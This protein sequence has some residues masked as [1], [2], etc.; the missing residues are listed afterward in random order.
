M[1]YAALL[2]EDD[3]IG[4]KTRDEFNLVDG[5]GNPKRNLFGDTRLIQNALWLKS[6]I[7]SSDGAVTRMASYLGV[8]EITIVGMV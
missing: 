7:I 2:M 6:R 5:A 4:K 1:C 3:A 8:P